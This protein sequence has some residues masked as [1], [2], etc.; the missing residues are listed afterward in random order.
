MKVLDIRTL[1]ICEPTRSNNFC[2]TESNAGKTFEGT[3]G[4][5]VPTSH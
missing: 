5:Q 3:A 4:S 2:L 1:Y